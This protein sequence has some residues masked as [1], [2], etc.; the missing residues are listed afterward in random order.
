MQIS[1]QISIL[2]VQTSV[3]FFVATVRFPLKGRRWRQSGNE[4]PFRIF[5]FP[6]KYTLRAQIVAW[7]GCNIA[8]AS[9][10]T[11]QTN[12]N[13]AFDQETQCWTIFNSRQAPIPGALFTRGALWARLVSCIGRRH[14]SETGKQKLNSTIKGEMGH[15]YNCAAM[16]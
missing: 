1:S 9:R 3:D 8:Q 15:E 16:H 12:T 14:W 4:G 7:G 10:T 13:V 11:S 2:K 5:D 6:W